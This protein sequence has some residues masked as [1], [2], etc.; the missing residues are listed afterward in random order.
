MACG[1]DMDYLPAQGIDQGIIFPLRIS[2]NNIVLSNKKGVSNLPFC[3]ERFSGTWCSQDQTVW[4][5]QLLP[6]NHNHVVGQGVQSI[7]KRLALHKQ[8]LCCE[9]HK[10]SRRCG[11]QRPFYR[12]QIQSQRETAHQPRLLHIIQT[13]QGTVIFLRNARRLEHRIV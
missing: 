11:G 8:F 10:N 6:V 9:R 12:D 2:D 7:V 13:A 1:G 4:I 3:R 5:F